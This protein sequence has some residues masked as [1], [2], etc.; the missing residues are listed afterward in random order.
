MATMDGKQ[1]TKDNTEDK[2]SYA[3]NGTAGIQN[4]TAPTGF[5]FQMPKQEPVAWNA[6]VPPL[7]PEMKDG[8]TISVEYTASPAA[9]VQ[10]PVGTA[11][12]LFSNTALERLD[13]RPSTNIY[14]TPFAP[15]VPD[16]MT[17]AEGEHPE[18]VQGWNDCRQLMLQTRNNK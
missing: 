10:E 14:I 8:E 5:F 1:M 11:G 12:Q 6:G 17:T 4:T 16:V 7:Y 3:G 15:V 18:Y 9:P 2:V 13:L